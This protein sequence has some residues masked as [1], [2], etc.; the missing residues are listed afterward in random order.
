MK[1]ARTS[2]RLIFQEHN[3][4]RFKHWRDVG[5][6]SLLWV[7]A[8][9]G[10]GKSVLARYLVDEIL[11]DS[12][13]TLCYFFF[14]DGFA[15]QQSITSCICALL[16]QLLI[17]RDDLITEAL[18]DDVEKQGGISS[19][20]SYSL[21]SL[22][23]RIAGSETAGEIICV[24]DALD[25]CYEDDMSSWIY[26]IQKLF[27]GAHKPRLKML[28]TSRPYQ[29]IQ[30]E[31][32]AL[33]DRLPTVHLRG[34][35]EDE[36]GQITKEVDLVIRNRV[37]ALGQ[38]RRLKED[39]TRHVQGLLTAVPNRTYL[40][41]TLTLYNLER[42]PAFT[43]GSALKLVTQ[44]PR[45][46]DEAY[47]SILAKSVDE[48]KARRLLHIVLAAARPLTLNEIS[49]A[50]AIE[51]HHVV[52]EDLADYLEPVE[53]F[54]D[55]L[56]DI[57]GLLLIVVDKKAYLLHQTVREFLVEP[58]RQPDHLVPS[59]HSSPFVWK[60]S[61]R[62]G[63][64][65]K[66]MAESCFYYINM[67]VKRD[68]YQENDGVDEI[69]AFDH[70]AVNQWVKHFEQSDV[71]TSEPLA[72][73]ILQFCGQFTKR[74]YEAY[75]DL[76]P[77]SDSMPLLFCLYDE[78]FKDIDPSAVVP[79]LI[80]AAYLGLLKIVKLLVETTEVDI[81]VRDVGFKFT[82]LEW[83]A[84]K[85]RSTS[86]KEHVDLIRYLASFDDVEL[87]GSVLQ[88]DGTPKPEEF[89]RG[90]HAV[91]DV[92]LRSGKLDDVNW[93]DHL[94][95]TA[96]HWAASSGNMPLLRLLLAADGVDVNAREIDGTTPLITAVR[97]GNTEVVKMLVAVGQVNVNATNQRGI[98]PLMC[99]GEQEM[100]HILLSSGRVDLETSLDRAIGWKSHHTLEALLIYATYKAHEV[101]PRLP[102]AKTSKIGLVDDTDDPYDFKIDRRK[103]ENYALS[104]SYI[105]PDGEEE[106]AR[107]LAVTMLTYLQDPSLW[108]RAP[109]QK[110]WGPIDFGI[111]T[112]MGKDYMQDEDWGTDSGSSWRSSR[113]S[114]CSSSWSSSGDCSVVSEEREWPLMFSE[115]PW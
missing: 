109:P 39:E 110:H 25:E 101:A 98:T 82:P 48:K 80:V 112:K 36:V 100:V 18:L 32:R 115:C 40:W 60:H 108:V 74:L 64:S 20:S 107:H 63:T 72:V 69:A 3:H 73:A 43:K 91:V 85:E 1:T 104:D 19:A 66:I 42:M 55:T 26:Q 57:S 22:F 111:K 46:V 16:H 75:E 4:E 93:K 41:V 61:F 2:R 51:E 76:D 106:E 52:E 56:R 89:D 97:Q 5:Q 114:S 12:T 21:W 30:W 59:R 10:S 11:Q 71:D 53:R 94:G 13:K 79:V 83:A 34:E 70:Y 7:S 68:Q 27:L 81:N 15:D 65:H 9:P 95:R 29:R 31:F 8:D 96:L 38:R 67:R 77:N 102:T 90:W 49:I 86:N 44:I 28:F 45:T 35:D 50:L 58:L 23:I 92:V 24:I 103:T 88:V 113:S 78:D 17:Q 6:S 54:R 47:E 84:Y 33:E 14:K 87:D 105:E 37:K 62:T 99:A